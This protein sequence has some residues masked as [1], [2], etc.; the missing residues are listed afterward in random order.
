MQLSKG[1]KKRGLGETLAVASA[2]LLAAT[3]A[4]V[5]QPAGAQDSGA[6]REAVQFGPD[7]TNDSDDEGGF[8]PGATYAELDS[9][10]LVY[11]EPGG[12]VQAIEP[13]TDFS[14]HG[15]NGDTL[16]LGL[17]ADAVSGATP[18][19][20]VPSDQAQTF[21]TPVKAKGSSVSVAGASGGSTIIQ[22]PPTPGQIAQAALGRQ[23]I[24]APDT[25]PMDK[26]FRD[27]RYGFDAGW[28][29]P[30]GGLSD[31]GFGAGYSIERDY[32]AVT[33]NIHVAQNF[34]A[35]NTAVSL[36]LNA[37]L[38]TSF[39]YGGVPTPLT[40]MSPLWKSP[41][42][43][44]KTQ[45]G[46]VLGLTQVVSRHW[47]MQLDLSFDAQSGY[48][49]DPYRIV[50]VVDSVTGR[51][52]QSLYESRPKQRQSESVFWD[53]KLA[54]GPTVTEVSF[55]YFRDDWGITSETAELAER[56]DLGSRFFIEPNVRWYQQ[57]SAKFFHNFLVGGQPLPQFVSSDSRLGSFR[58]YTG[59][60]KFGFKPTMRTE[61]YIRGEYY[62][63][64]GNAHPANAFGQLKSQNLFAGTKAAFVLLGYNWDFH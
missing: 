51:P 1:R 56:I 40:V 49:N 63:Q 2:G 21:V 48:E 30:V 27:R 52:F 13:A 3:A 41:S 11:Q 37:E 36:A 29:Q 23:Y 55:R 9:A 12:R 53:N 15:A 58:A 47:L 7:G 57:S 33:A 31:M 18:N 6:G 34:N 4:A 64:M 38:D 35:D 45:A 22:L 61:F 26:G 32:Q 50:S 17:I 25:L 28:S 59:G 19:G 10:I 8:G 39:P 42:S 5:V 62:D 16:S 54:Y 44:D 14:A 24:V 20:A 60:L 43:K 46:F